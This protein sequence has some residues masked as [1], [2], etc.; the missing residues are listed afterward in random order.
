MLLAKVLADSNRK[1]IIE[2]WAKELGA[3]D[4]RRW[5]QWADLGSTKLLLQLT[6]APFRERFSALAHE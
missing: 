5:F 6:E 3:A 2:K 1:S 4:M